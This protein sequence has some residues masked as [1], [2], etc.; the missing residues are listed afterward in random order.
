MLGFLEGRTKFSFC[1]F[2]VTKERRGLV[3][4]GIVILFIFFITISLSICS[5]DFLAF[6]MF[7]IRSAP[8]FLP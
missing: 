4:L 3:G 5:Y 1:H 8:P 6:F 7:S 2:L